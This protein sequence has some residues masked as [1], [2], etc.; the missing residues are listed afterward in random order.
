MQENTLV[1]PETSFQTY[2][3]TDFGPSHLLTSKL[4][5][6]VGCDVTDQQEIELTSWTSRNCHLPSER[7]CRLRNIST[8]ITPTGSIVKIWRQRMGLSHYHTTIPHYMPYAVWIRD[9]SSYQQELDVSEEQALMF[10]TVSL[11]PYPPTCPW[12]TGALLSISVQKKNTFG[13][14]TISNTFPQNCM[15]P[16]SSSSMLL[17]WVAQ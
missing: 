7:Q 16:Y 6:A 9:G 11:C 15:T 8:A 17:V 12:F 14:I 5:I 13:F 4:T 10:R 2:T 3:E 1:R